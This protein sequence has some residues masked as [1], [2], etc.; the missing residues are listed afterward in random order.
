MCGLL[1]EMDFDVEIISCHY[2]EMPV[3][4]WLQIGCI[5]DYRLM[6]LNYG[7]LSESECLFLICENFPVFS[8]V[9]CV[10]VLFGCD[11]LLRVSPCGLC[12]CVL[13]GESPVGECGSVVC[14]EWVC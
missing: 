3:R 1:Y 11:H 12:V 7:R 14:S 10:F 4:R 2:A 8:L 5:S 9:G 6:S 13:A